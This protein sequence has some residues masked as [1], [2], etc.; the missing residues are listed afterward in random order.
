M[1]NGETKLLVC[2][3]DSLPWAHTHLLQCALLSSEDIYF[4]QQKGKT[5]HKQKIACNSTKPQIIVYIFNQLNIFKLR[6]VYCYF[7]PNV[8]TYLI[9]LQNT[10]QKKLIS[11]T[12]FISIFT[13]LV[14]NF[15]CTFRAEFLSRLQFELEASAHIS[16]ESS[17]TAAQAEIRLLA[18]P[19]T[20]AL[21]YQCIIYY[22]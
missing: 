2:F 14:S 21:K 18:A 4:H 1:C 8:I 13:R 11:V 20:G 15:T 22:M 7:S 17:H 12:S 3:P 10:V 19:G 9:G 5:S 6:Y 16:E